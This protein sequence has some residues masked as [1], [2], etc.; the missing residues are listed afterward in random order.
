MQTLHDRVHDV[1]TES[2]PLAAFRAELC[3]RREAEGLNYNEAAR[4]VKPKFSG[5]RWRELEQRTDT[6]PRRATII[7]LAKALGWDPVTALRLAG[8]RTLAPVE[9]HPP[10]SDDRRE[11]LARLLPRLSD[12]QLLVLL[13]QARVMVDP[14]ASEATET[15]ELAVLETRPG[16][17]A[18]QTEEPQ[19]EDLN[20]VDGEGAES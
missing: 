16:A 7:K 8:E 14:E 5:Q 13:H 15:V 18:Q 12:R 11:H 1:A 20:G 6:R 17:A 10:P 3:A 9:S 4:L 2:D 19:H